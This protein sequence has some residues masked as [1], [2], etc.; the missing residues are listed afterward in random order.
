MVRREAVSGATHALRCPTPDA[1]RGTTTHTHT[2]P[3]PRTT[4]ILVRYV[5]LRARKK[6]K[7]PAAYTLYSHPLHNA[8]V[9]ANEPAEGE[10]ANCRYQ[11]VDV[12]ID[13]T[14]AALHSQRHP[15]AAKEGTLQKLAAHNTVSLHL[16]TPVLVQVAPTRPTGELTVHYGDAYDRGAYPPTCLQ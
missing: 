1:A 6:A 15:R 2:D 11:T 5:T 3:H 10:T 13:M 4:N 9:L 8:W 14:P 16:V 7:E 12:N